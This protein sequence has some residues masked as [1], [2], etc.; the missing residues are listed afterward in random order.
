MKIALTVRVGVC[1]VDFCEQITATDCVDL[2]GALS[3]I[4]CFR[5]ALDE[6]CELH[7]PDDCIPIELADEFCSHF[8]SMYQARERYRGDQGC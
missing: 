2:G 6:E 1:D 7:A 4:D 3:C 8:P 5:R